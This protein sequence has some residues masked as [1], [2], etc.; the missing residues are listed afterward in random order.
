MLVSTYSTN[1]PER[2]YLLKGVI[3]G[4]RVEI[5][6]SLHNL[7]RFD[8]DCDLLLFCRDT[9]SDAGGIDWNFPR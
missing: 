1:P 3:R 4:H 2:L 9:R 7:G 6:L 8:P 5:L